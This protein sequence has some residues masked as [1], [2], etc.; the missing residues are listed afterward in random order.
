MSEPLLRTAGLTRHFRVGKLLSRQMRRA[1]MRPRTD[2]TKAHGVRAR[3]EVECSA[4]EDP[5][6]C[7]ADRTAVGRHRREH[8]ETHARQPGRDLVGRQPSFRG[9]DAEEVPRPLW[10][11]NHRVFDWLQFLGKPAV[12]IG[13]PTLLAFWSYGLRAG[14]S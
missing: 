3:T 4:I 2:M 14:W 6:D 8:E 13:A 1:H 9:V 12:A 11:L 5:V 7:A 10:W